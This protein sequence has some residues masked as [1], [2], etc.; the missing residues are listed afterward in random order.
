MNIVPSENIKML[1]LYTTISIGICALQILLRKKVNFLPICK[2]TIVLP[3]V[4]VIS[5][6]LSGIGKAYWAMAVA[7]DISSSIWNKGISRLLVA[8]SIALW[9]T[10]LLSLIYSLTSIILKNQRKQ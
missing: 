3:L 7:N 4:Y 10:V 2:L 9:I 1:I 6:G 5:W 8:G